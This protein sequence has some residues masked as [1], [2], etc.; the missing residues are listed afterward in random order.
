MGLHT[1]RSSETGI[2]IDPEW[3][4]RSKIGHG[5]SDQEPDHFA[6]FLLGTKRHLNPPN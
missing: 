4:G 5:E 6:T 2:P 3:A 1:D